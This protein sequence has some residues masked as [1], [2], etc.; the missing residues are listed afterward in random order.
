VRKQLARGR[1][2][3]QTMVTVRSVDELRALT[4]PI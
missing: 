2:A 1:L 3:A 4:E